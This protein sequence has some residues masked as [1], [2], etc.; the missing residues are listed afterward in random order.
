MDLKMREAK[1]SLKL[2]QVETLWREYAIQ[3]KLVVD[4]GRKTKMFMFDPEL[5]AG[6]NTQLQIFK[7]STIDTK[8]QSLTIQRLEEEFKS[9][10]ECSYI[11]TQ[12]VLNFIQQNSG[13][14]VDQ[15]I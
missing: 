5:S 2:Q 14:T 3:H 1:G 9:V 11:T 13:R 12:P 7:P 4:L 15:L 8:Q 10:T 6:R